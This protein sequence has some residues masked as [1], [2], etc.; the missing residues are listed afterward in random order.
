M[1]EVRREILDV[2][3]ALGEETRFTIFRTI[4]GA[5]DP[6]TVQDLVERIGMHHS[7]IRIHLNKLVDAGLIISQK[8]HRPGVVG[9]PQLAFLPSPHAVSITLPPRDYRFLARLAMD[10][11]TRT[12]DATDLDEFGFMW[13]RDYIRDRGR[14]ADGPF[15]LAQAIDVVRREMSGSGVSTAV[16]RQDKSFELSIHNCVFAELAPDFDPTICTLHQAVL[17]GMVS[18]ICAEPIDWEHS[19][20]ICAGDRHCVAQITPRVD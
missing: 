18:Q 11:A 7:A 12:D 5:A 3:R 6:L 10:L 1:Y 16:E 20:C 17:R 14:A 15:P 19:A 9:R 4:A 13:G 8:R 2:A